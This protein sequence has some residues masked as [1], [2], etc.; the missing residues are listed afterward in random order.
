[1]VSRLGQLTDLHQ[2]ETCRIKLTE[3]ARI[4]ASITAM[5]KVI[6]A[7]IDGMQ[8]AIDAFI[9]QDPT[10]SQNVKLLR[11]CKGVGPKSAQAILAMLPEIGALNRRQIAARRRRAHHQGQRLINPLR[12]HNRRPQSPARHS[13]HGCNDRQQTQSN[14]QGLLRASAG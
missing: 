4:K 14:L 2:S 1:M 9:A 6:K 10:L 7:Q 12:Q 11:S 8:D 13:V 3:G 5:L